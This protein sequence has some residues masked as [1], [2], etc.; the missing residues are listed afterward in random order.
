MQ[1]TL[2]YLQEELSFERDKTRRIYLLRKIGDRAFRSDPHFALDI[3]QRGLGLSR[4]VR[5]RAAEAAFLRAIGICQIRLLD[6]DKALDALWQSY[7]LFAALHRHEDRATVLNNVGTAYKKKGDYKEALDAFNKSCDVYEENGFHE[8]IGAVLN[9][10]GTIY[11]EIGDY[12]RALDSYQQCLR[13]REDK[14]HKPGIGYVLN[15]IGTVYWLLEDYD[16]ALDCFQKSYAIREEIGDTYGQ[17]LTL[18]NIGLIYQQRDDLVTALEYQTRVMKLYD[19]VD[20]RLGKAITLGH[21]GDLYRAQSQWRTALDYLEEARTITEEADDKASHVRILQNI[22]AIQFEKGELPKAFETL[23]TALG[24]A[25]AGGFR[26]AE[27]ELHE[28]IAATF[29]AL[30]DSDKAYRHLRR[31]SQIKDEV[32]NRQTQRKIAEMRLRAEIETANQEREIYRLQN[33]RLELQMQMKSKELTTLAMYLVQ[34]NE[35]LGRLK[36]RIR[37]E[38]PH[39]DTDVAKAVGSLVHEIDENV[40]SREDWS[41]FERQ[42]QEVHQD[43]IRQISEAFPKLTPTELKICALLKMNLAT[44]EIAQILSVS[45]RNVESHRYRLRKKLALA[46]DANLTSFLASM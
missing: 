6:Y 3:G 46:P 7:E 14:D 34:K 18:G 15:N 5:D 11:Q 36:Q 31:Y 27:Y 33:E 2:E 30:G 41:A 28:R 43:F 40:N 1:E 29:D 17:A 12:A 19:E 32:R 45:V 16:N 24:I 26:H 37:Q 22:G 4:E 23:N 10:I 8:Q 38:I 9:N 25:E 39:N 42:F 20:D 21:L 35:F 13:Y 44:K